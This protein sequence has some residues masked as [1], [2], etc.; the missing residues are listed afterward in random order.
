MTTTAQDP[1]I[2]QPAKAALATIT[3][4]AKQMSRPCF[5]FL[6]GLELA[7]ISA[8]FDALGVLS[9]KSHQLYAYRR[10]QFCQANKMT[11]EVAFGIPNA[12]LPA[13]I[14]TATEK[15]DRESALKKADATALE[16]LAGYD[17]QIAAFADN[18]EVAASWT[19]RK[20]KAA[21]AWAAERSRLSVPA[22]QRP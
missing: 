3:A 9:A 7:R 14:E 21:S 5:A 4:A 1:K 10:S 16:N 6:T 2:R 11:P 19:E 13:I 20:A 12:P 17:R 15:R 18:P 8:E 22:H